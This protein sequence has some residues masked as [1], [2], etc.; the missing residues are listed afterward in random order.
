[1]VLRRHQQIEGIRIQGTDEGGVKM[2][3][4]GEEE[5]PTPRP[6]HKRPQGRAYR[7]RNKISAREH[8]DRSLIL[9]AAE[10]QEGME[11]GY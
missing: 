1:M 2:R 10:K 9:N 5:E 7:E 6:S 11:P 4:M 8:R 3:D